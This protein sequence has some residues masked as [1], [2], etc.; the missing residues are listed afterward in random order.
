MHTQQLA[1]IEEL[2][3][4]LSVLDL[5]GL[6]RDC[7]FSFFLDSSMNNRELG[8]YSFMGGA[9]FLLL[10]SHADEVTVTA[11]NLSYKIKGSPFDILDRFLKQYQ[12]SC[13]M[14]SIPLT[15][16]AV[17]YFSYDLNHFIEHLPGATVDNLHFPESCFGFYDMVVVLDNIEGKTYIVSTGFPEMRER[18]RIDRAA[19]RIKEIKSKLVK[20][21]CVNHDISSR[22]RVSEQ[23]E[24][25]SN[26][27]RQGYIDTIAKAR[28]Y[29]IAGDI[30]EV[31][32]SQ[33]F[34]T[35]ILIPPYELYERLR[36]INPSPF[37]C[38]LDFGEVQIISASPER[39]LC[40]REDRVE[41]RP[42]KGTRPRGTT[43]FEDR[44]LA[45]ELLN[46]VKDRAENIMIV[47][48]VRNDLGRV[49]SYGTV[50]VAELAAL[51]TY[52]TVFH[53]TSAVVGN[54]RK[55]ISAIDVVKAAFPG[56]SITGAPKI[57]AMEI[58]GEL[59]PT[60]RS[61][62]TGSIGYIS[63]SG[64]MDLNIAIR[65]ILVHDQRACFQVGGAVVYDSNPEC[66]YQE[67]LHKA[68]ALLD[69]LNNTVN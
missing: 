51:E 19:A 60:R 11:G 66:E 54:L 27:T 5:F 20:I 14:P 21:K 8:R 45:N 23:V 36:K 7:P 38:Y 6:F 48:L 29:I 1:I 15:G 57:R 49:C 22:Q 65:T 13:S 26:F 31:N 30:F 12:V 63:F 47:D 17:G 46:S 4:E 68:K 64:N 18:Q 40:V 35:R 42:I 69:A 16:G 61:I 67:T 2:K 62:Y 32:I 41:T 50:K 9:P 43:P 37:A 34:E 55:G 3:T 28:Q 24:I 52:P 59:E 44:A 25:R 33:R 39:F 56:G 53:L 58:I 10:H